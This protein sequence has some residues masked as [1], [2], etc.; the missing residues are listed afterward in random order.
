MATALEL[1]L[2][3]AGLL[4]AGIAWFGSAKAWRLE[5]RPVDFAM[6]ILAVAWVLYLLA[7]AVYVV[8]ARELQPTFGLQEHV[9]DVLRACLLAS[10]AFFLLNASGSVR[11]WVLLVI[12]LNLAS[13]IVAVS[14]LKWGVSASPLVQGVATVLTLATAL[15]VTGSVVRHV[16]HTQTRRSWLVLAACTMGI[17]LWLCVIAVPEVLVVPKVPEVAVTP[18]SGHIGHSGHSMLPMVFHLYAFFIFVVWKLVSLAPDPN[19]TDANPG[20]LFGQNSKFQTMASVHTD[21]QFVAL[22]LKAERQ[23]ISHELHD[24]VGSQIVSILFAMQGADQP[25]KSFVMLSL[26]QCLT[27]LKLMVDALDSFDENVTQSLGRLR[28][29]VQHALDRH[30]IKMRW[31]V[32]ISDE[33]EAVRGIYAQQVLRIAQES[34][35]NVMRHAKARTVKVSCRFVPEFCHLSLEITDDGVGLAA[36]AS[37]RLAGHGLASMKRRASAIGGNLHVSSR[38]GGGTCVRLTV[39]LPHVKAKPK[40]INAQLDAEASCAQRAAAA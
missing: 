38:T 11:P 39:P 29:R 16:R 20:S 37:G 13:G 7:T 12:G 9:G 36:T 35:A 21:D 27:D 17:G 8:A 3:F 19:N 31:D 15:V 23:R 33:L 22:A 34:V 30:G 5:N 1:F 18:R 14:W 28:Y 25:Q 4:L 10:L 26:E 40:N 6:C 24:N 32:D 2:I